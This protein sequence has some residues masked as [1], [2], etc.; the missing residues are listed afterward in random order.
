MCEIEVERRLFFAHKLKRTASGSH[1]SL[2]QQT[3][4]KEQAG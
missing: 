4:I 2:R 1:Y 3:A